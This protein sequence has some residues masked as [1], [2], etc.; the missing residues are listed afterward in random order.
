L[1]ETIVTSTDV[2]HD[3]NHDEATSVESTEEVLNDSIQPDKHVEINTVLDKHM[4]T[5]NDENPSHEIPSDS[6]LGTKFQDPTRGEED[7]L[8]SNE[9]SPSRPGDSAQLDDWE[10]DPVVLPP[11]LVN[12][13]DVSKTS[14]ITSSSNARG[15]STQSKPS[16][17]ASFS[18]QDKRTKRN[19]KNIN[20]NGNAYDSKK[21]SLLDAYVEPTS[22]PSTISPLPSQ[23]IEATPA[24]E[25]LEPEVDDDWEKT[26]EKIEQKPVTRRL[27]P[28]G[29]KQQVRL[30]SGPIVASIPQVKARYTYSREDIM[31]YKPGAV[32]DRPL[33]MNMYTDVTFLDESAKQPSRVISTKGYFNF[34]MKNLPEKSTNRDIRDSSGSRDSREFRSNSGYPQQFP[35]Q[36]TEESSQWKRTDR[37]DNFITPGPNQSRK[38]N[39]RQNSSATRTPL[40]VVADPLAELCTE[41]MQILNKITPQT[42]EKLTGKMCEIPIGTNALLDKLIELVFEKAIQ[43]QSFSNLYA[44]MCAALEKR[45]RYWAF[46]QIVYHLDEKRYFWM[47]D[48]EFGNELAGP[49]TSVED[50]IASALSSETLNI[51]I[52]NFKPQVEELIMT[53]DLLIKVYFIR[54]V[55]LINLLINDFLIVML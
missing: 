41:V 39:N 4:T 42:F 51:S 18:T 5:E 21:G 50:C 24:T 25:P 6:I 16:I 22:S 36:G 33:S 11:S 53:S 7:T 38:G 17:S 1:S 20:A 12:A 23:L 29:G 45:S 40:I 2:V 15:V 19:S 8:I 32:P 3:V 52:V 30:N 34:E 10:L 47:M 44:D 28:G 31:K 54:T 14:S 9:N 55:I 48:L 46:L 26:A 35:N 13:V 43:E 27:M 49:Y 37:Q